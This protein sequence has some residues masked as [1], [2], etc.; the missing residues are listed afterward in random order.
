M[1]QWLMLLLVALTILG[2]AG[3]GRDPGPLEGTWRMTGVVPATITFR[4]GETESM[5]MIE[6]VS[7][8]VRGKDVLVTYKN[9]LAEGTSIRYTVLSPNHLRSELGDLRRIQ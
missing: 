4:A 2:L 7:Y 1:K 8:G 3:C 5:G 6:K 9:G